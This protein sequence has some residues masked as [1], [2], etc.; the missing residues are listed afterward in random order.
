MFPLKSAELFAAA[1]E[2]RTFSTVATTTVT[3]QHQG[4]EQVFENSLF[5]PAFELAK[6]ALGE[7]VEKLEQQAG[8]STSLSAIL[9]LTAVAQKELEDAHARL[10]SLCLKLAPFWPGDFFTLGD[11]LLPNLPFLQPTLHHLRLLGE[12]LDAACASQIGQLLFAL[13]DLT[14]P[15]LYQQPDT[16]P[17]QLNAQAF[18]LVRPEVQPLIDNPHIPGADDGTGT[19]KPHVIQVIDGKP[20][21]AFGDLEHA[22]TIL[23]V[24]E[25]VTSSN[26]DKVAHNI[27]EV[28]QLYE[29]LN[30]ERGGVAVIYYDYEAPPSLP[31]G[32]SPHYAEAAA[33]NYQ[34]YKKSLR[35]LYPTAR[36]ADLG[37]SYGSLMISTAAQRPDGLE[38]DIFIN[39]GSP[40]LGANHA[41]E[42][43]LNS[44]NPEIISV[45]NHHDL[46][47]YAH[48]PF[49]GIHGADPTTPLFGATE[50]WTDIPGNH[51]YITNLDF[52]ERLRTK[53]N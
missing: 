51:S 30:H 7:L 9:Y 20:A 44:T 46:A 12:T 22:H 26:G 13:N 34:R 4:W 28:Q 1:Q 16:T 18:P 48:N 24:V 47:R 25:G 52:Q 6:T 10:I 50:A 27:N 53:L 42:L 8:L 37:H 39:A 17:A 32:I 31:A 11:Q 23:T 35:E 5:G 43:H 36:L 2:H 19:T 29:Q 41:T 21:V 40:G 3:H 33:D 49:R 45:L 15:Q 14:K 38:T